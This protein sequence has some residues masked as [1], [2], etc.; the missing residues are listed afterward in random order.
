MV[1]YAYEVFRDKMEQLLEVFIHVQLC[2]MIRSSSG[3]LSNWIG[4][5]WG[6]VGLFSKVNY[7]WMYKLTEG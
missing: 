4:F 2:P 6:Q 1:G 5:F 7:S 3:E